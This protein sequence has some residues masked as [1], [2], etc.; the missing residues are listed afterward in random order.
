MK[1]QIDVTLHVRTR[2]NKIGRN[3]NWRRLRWEYWVDLETEIPYGD[4][5]PA[6]DRCAEGDQIL[7]APHYQLGG[8]A[9]AFVPNNMHWG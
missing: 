4:G 1:P 5:G 7:A 9:P 6:L 3:F 2:V 8:L